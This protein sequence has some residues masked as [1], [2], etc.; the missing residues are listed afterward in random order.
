MVLGVVFS[1]AV[2][3]SQARRFHRYRVRLYV[4]SVQIEHLDDPD[5]DFSHMKTIT[6]RSG[7]AVL[8]R[9]RIGG[10]G[11]T[12]EELREHEYGLSWWFVGVRATASVMVRVGENRYVQESI[13]TPG[14]WGV[15]SDADPEHFRELARSELLELRGILETMGVRGLDLIDRAVALQCNDVEEVA[16]V[17]VGSGRP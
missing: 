7:R 4:A 3:P 5:P 17:F 6:D 12:E 13:T 15:E 2:D 16:S 14:I 8:S 1:H 11:I 10:S 9:R